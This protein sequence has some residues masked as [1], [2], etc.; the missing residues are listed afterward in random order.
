MNNYDKGLEEDEYTINL[1]A[2]VLDI[3]KGIKKFGWLVLLLVMTSAGISC[4]RTYQSY[5][6][7]YT[8]SATFTVGLSKDSATDS[9]YEDNLQSYQMSK[10]FPYIV[11]S[12]VLKSV[13]AED[14]G[15]A[16]I[17]ESISAENVENTNLFTIEVSSGNA[18][19]A[20]DVLQSVIVNYPK[21]AETVV[22]RTQLVMLDE[23]GVPKEPVNTID[24]KSSVKQG[25]IPGASFG[26]LI[27]LL[28]ALTRR[29]IHGI[30][31]LV[32]LTSVKHIGSLPEVVFKKRGKKVNKVISIINKK[33]F[34]WYKENLC[35]IRTRVE[36]IA[37]ANH[38]KSI[39]IT[40]AIQ[41]EGKSTFAF[42][43][44]VSLAE[45]GKKV[46]L[47]D[48]DLHH[49]T[50]RN[51]NSMQEDSPGLE[52]V[53]NGKVELKDAL[54]YN[55]DLKLYILAGTK[56]MSN[57]SEMIGTQKMKEIIS[58]LKESADYVVIDTAPSYI[59]SDTYEL[60]K[61]TDGVIFVVKQDYAKGKHIV[62]SLEH[63]TES[64]NSYIMGFVLNGVK[65]GLD[66]FGYGNGYGSYGH[67]S[68]GY[69]NF[70]YSKKTT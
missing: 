36:K 8:A 37:E 24:Y 61:F 41:G 23:T 40:S 55:E 68:Y 4:L 59:L 47:L 19:R 2:F 7:Y 18:Q 15:V 32:K 16:Y 65:A 30:E 14:L 6:P 45:N 50:I 69:G 5:S 53:L 11:T 66:G 27:I 63:I 57:A 3:W 54:K 38:I 49:P 25:I 28:Y 39:L 13:I 62:E 21:V 22:G 20:Y 1:S 51:I 46:I 17:S 42:N 33:A 64:S 58:E 67:G 70:G 29:T 26:G 60:A 52:V 44:S 56:Y 10:T 48:A 35:K 9:I 34:P 12:G 43:L 31:D